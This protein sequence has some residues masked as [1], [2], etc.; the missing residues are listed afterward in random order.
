MFIGEAPGS[1]EDAQGEPFVGKAGQ[2]LTRI[3]Q[4][5]GLTPRLGLY[6]QHPQVPARHPRPELRQPQADSPG[7]ADLHPI[8]FAK[9]TSSAPRSSLPLEPLPSRVFWAKTHGITRLRGHWQTFRG[10]P[11]MPTYHPAYLLRNQSL[12]E[13]AKSGKTCSRSW[14]N[15][16]CPSP[17]NNATSSCKDE[18]KGCDSAGLFRTH[19]TISRSR[20]QLCHGRARSSFRLRAAGAGP[21][22]GR[23][24]A[25]I[26]RPRHRTPPGR[27]GLQP[28]DRLGL[29]VQV[30]HHDMRWRADG[31]RLGPRAE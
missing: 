10:I 12:S 22:A 24:Q 19:A 2:L 16:P 5:M 31:P 6:R 23:T 11:L 26:G 9:S 21:R 29:V 3:I 17:K 15:S 7:N 20:A 28:Q 14:P 27:Q 18:G 4:T 1:D 30:D 13:N 25:T 8:S